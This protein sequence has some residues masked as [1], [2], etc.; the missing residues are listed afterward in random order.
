MSDTTNG[1]V[2]V[3]VQLDP[4]VAELAALREEFAAYKGQVRR[5]AIQTA[6]DQGWC[7]S[8]LNETLTEKL[9]LEAHDKQVNRIRM[10]VDVESEVPRGADRTRAS[11]HELSRRA[12]EFVKAAL[13]DGDDDLKVGDVQYYS[14][15][16]IDVD[17]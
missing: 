12:V 11:R 10:F 15:D 6:R 9:G 4:A 7:R 8:G 16:T 5:V 2:A 14:F 17:D 3:A 1:G 13:A